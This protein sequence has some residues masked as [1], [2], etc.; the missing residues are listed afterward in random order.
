MTYIR[1]VSRKRPTLNNVPEQ[2]QKCVK[3]ALKK[4][5]NMTKKIALLGKNTVAV[6]ALETLLEKNVDI[7]LVCPNN[8]DMGEN[9]WQLSLL[10]KANDYDLPVKQFSKIKHVSSI[11]YLNTLNLDFI[12]SIQYDQIINQDVINTAR[13]GA[14]NLHFAPLPKY[15]GVSP[16]AL[17]ML[18]GETEFGVSLHYMD[19]GVD[20]GDIIS[21]KIFNI[22]DVENARK[23]YDLCVLKSSELFNDAIDRILARENARFCQDNSKALY[24]SKD[25]VN[26]KQNKINFNQCSK[27]LMNWI[28]AFI[29]DPFQYPIFMHNGETYEVVSV[30]SDFRKNEFELPGTL[31]FSDEKTFKFATHDSYI[32]LVVK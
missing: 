2:N 20:T 28:K 14:I 24:Y 23:L 19:P 5:S 27:S 6:N 1:T 26:F 3:L 8:S 7:V 10:K 29:F 17:A 18:N 16:V 9:G 30:S 22:E 12:F 13:Y 21:Q 4:G 15:R 25:T 32:N 11:E 31:I